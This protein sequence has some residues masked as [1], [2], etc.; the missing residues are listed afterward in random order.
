MKCHFKCLDGLDDRRSGINPPDSGA[1]QLAEGVTQEL[2]PWEQTLKY[3]IILQYRHG[4]ARNPQYTGKHSS[5]LLLV[6]SP[7][8]VK[9][10]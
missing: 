7:D 10:Q 1:A 9:V 5:Q 2:K 4:A 3:Y 6:N 8:E